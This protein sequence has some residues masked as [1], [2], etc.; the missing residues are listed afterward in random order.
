MLFIF[1]IYTDKTIQIQ[2]YTNDTTLTKMSERFMVTHGEWALRNLDIIV[3]NVTKG[4]KAQSKL[5]YMVRK[6]LA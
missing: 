6:H 1:I 5:V 2:P 4:Q 3:Q